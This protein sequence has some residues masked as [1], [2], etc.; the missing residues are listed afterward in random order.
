MTRKFLS[1]PAAAP[2]KETQGEKPNGQADQTPLFRLYRLGTLAISF[3]G[4]L[5]ITLSP[6]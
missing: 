1:S 3:L 5:Q 6:S 4:Y 2:P